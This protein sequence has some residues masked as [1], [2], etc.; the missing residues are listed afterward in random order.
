M[1]R[2]Q[3]NYWWLHLGPTDMV[4][5]PDRCCTGVGVSA[6][7]G[8]GSR[9]AVFDRTVQAAIRLLAFQVCVAMASINAGDRQS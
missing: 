3:T 7:S 6:S 5:T 2:T 9:E 8:P 1:R 4:F